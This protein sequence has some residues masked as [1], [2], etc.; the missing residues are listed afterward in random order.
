MLRHLIL[1]HNGIPQT[2]VHY[3]PGETAAV[4]G[5]RDG[6]QEVNVL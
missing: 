4:G 1:V 5:K 2:D 3:I 6:S